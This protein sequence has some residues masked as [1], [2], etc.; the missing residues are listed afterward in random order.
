MALTDLSTV[1]IFD[2]VIFQQPVPDELLPLVSWK[3]VRGN[4]LL[5]VEVNPA[6][7]TVGWVG[8]A[9]VATANAETFSQDTYSIARVMGEF[10]LGEGNQQIYSAMM[11]QRKA[12]ADVK[13][14]LLRQAVGN[15]LVVGTGTMDQPTGLTIASSNTV[16]GGSATLTLTMLR[17]LLQRIVTHGGRCDYLVMSGQMINRFRSFYDAAPQPTPAPSVVDARTGEV[18]LA[19]SGV[20]IL[21]CDHLPNTAG[22]DS[23]V[24]AINLD[25]VCLI[26]PEGVGDRGLVVSDME[27]RSNG[28]LSVRLTQNVGVALIEQGGVA[29][30]TAVRP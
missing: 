1:Q 29:V 16:A 4:A 2:R 8:V 11:D 3:A 21:R 17:D 14:I 30:L 20:P 22:V 23:Q 18:R 6:I 13:R 5:I 19:C 27:T 26:Y 12:Q 25:A 15:A 7:G 24:I 10:D 9:A 28:S